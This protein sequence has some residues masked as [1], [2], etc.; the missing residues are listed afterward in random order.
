MM[1][2]KARDRGNAVTKNDDALNSVL[3]RK[4]SVPARSNKTDSGVLK[5]MITE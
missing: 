2:K 1:K 3:E 4:I 5:K